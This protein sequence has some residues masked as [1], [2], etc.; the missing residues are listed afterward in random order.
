MRFKKMEMILRATEPLT[1]N[2]SSQL[3]PSAVLNGINRILGNALTC[4]TEQEL[5]RLCLSVAEELTSSRFG[6]I[7]RLNAQGELD[8]IAI[9]DLGW[10]ACTMAEPVGHRVLPTGLAARA[11]YRRVLLDGTGN[12]TNDPAGDPDRIGVPQGHPALQAFLGVPLCH[13][14][15][16]IGMVAV[17][18]RE[19]G[20]REID[21]HALESLAPTIGQA[22]LAKRSEQALQESKQRYKE[23]VQHANSAIIRWKSDGTF[24]FINEYAQALFGYH[25]TEVLG[26]HVRLLVPQ[27]ESTGGDLSQLVQDIVDHPVKYQKVINEN[28]CKD[29]QRVWMVWTNRAIVNERGEQE[30]L[31]VGSDYT[32]QKRAEEALKKSESW[33]AAA[34]QIARLGVWE[35][36]LSTGLTHMDHRC[37][38]VFGIVEDRPISDDEFLSMVHLEDRARVESDMRAAQDP[39]GTGLYE[40]DYRITRADGTMRWLT[41]RAHAVMHSDGQRGAKR[42]IGTVM[43]ITALKQNEVA[44]L[45][46]ERRLRLSLES[47]YVISFEWN[48]A[49]G[50]VF[51][52]TSRDPA[53]PATPAAAGSFEEVVKVIHP[54]DR[55]QFHAN[56]KSAMERTDGR[57]ENEYR[58]VHP[59]GEIHYLHE[60]GYF[61]RDTMGRPSRLIGLSRDMTDQ[62]NAENSLRHSEERFELLA[63]VAERLLRAE[64]PQAIVED[65]CQLV[66]THID[67]QFFFNYLVEVPGKQMQ[68]NAYAGIPEEAAESIRQLDFGVAVC[69]CVAQDCERIIA[70]DIQN[71]NDL[72]TQLV[73]SFGVQAYCCHPLMMHD[74]LIGTL[75]FGTKTRPTFTADEV[76]L[77]KSVCDQVAVAMQRLLSKRELSQLNKSLEQRVVERTKLAEDRAM[78]LRSL[79]VKMIE[80]EER[81][82][83]RFADLLHEDL[84]Q[85]LAA[86]RFQLQAVSGD[87]CPEPELDHV[88]RI[89]EESIAKSRRLTH[90]LSPPVMYHGSLSSAM[91]WLS[92]QMKEHFGLSVHLE[93][94]NMPELKNSPVKIFVFRAVQELLFNIVKHAGVKS[95]SV[96]LSGKNSHLDVTVSDHGKGFDKSDLERSKV[97]KGFGL[98]SI[99]ERA[100][101]IGGDLI[102]ESEPGQGSRI[103]LTVPVQ[104]ATGEIVPVTLEAPL[105]AVAQ[106]TPSRS[107]GLRVLF[108]DD[109]KVMRQGLIRLITSQP[110]IEVAGEAANGKEAVELARQLHPDVILMDISMPEMD[111]IEATQRI[112]AVMPTVRVIGLSMF[113]DKSS[114]QNI[115]NAGADCFVPKTASPA[116]LLKAIYG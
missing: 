8:H 115:I 99:R 62:K 12:F 72:R 36:D 13:A 110:D 27:T 31:A 97:E 2:R 108:V 107:A 60:N 11:I 104:P 98:I 5:G 42:Y 93:S 30:I 79:A 81:E 3:V 17:A 96:L 74:R 91:E 64:N 92:G 103:H 80:V 21:R 75:S 29:G 63:N 53:L 58:I 73:K 100:H 18:N 44:L 114:A 89:L 23:L 78:Q 71:S 105:Y 47:A 56:L 38:E 52:L 94:E 102:I 88:S 86:A 76:A 50:K 84:Q 37:R 90:E 28:V 16:T 69:G 111:G 45:E 10:A 24:T 116:E 95:A 106:E 14:G 48:I 55:D 25:Y 4:K 43:D 22:L 112:K 32:E 87:K 39:Q 82:R 49:S 54:K 7:G 33:L 9:S 41:V 66:M 113:E 34:V 19:G 59:D 40:S 15:E 26:Q 68:L 109:H 61:E 65:L 77:M 83:R 57:Y 85:M 70:E 35:H 1:A 67:C 6:F 46:N 51:R 20:Y 101:H